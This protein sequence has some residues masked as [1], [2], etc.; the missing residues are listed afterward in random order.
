MPTILKLDNWP[1]YMLWL[2]LKPPANSSSGW[3]EELFLVSLSSVVMHTDCEQYKMGATGWHSISEYHKTK[4]NIKNKGSTHRPLLPPWC[5]ISLPFFWTPVSR[6]PPPRPTLSKF[7][8]ITGPCSFLSPLAVRH[9][10]R[11]H[12][13]MEESR[14]L[15]G[16]PAVM[17]LELGQQEV[18]HVPCVWH[19]SS[20]IHDQAHYF[21]TI[22]SPQQS[23]GPWPTSIMN[24]YLPDGSQW[25][26]CLLGTGSLLAQW[27]SRVRVLEI[28]LGA[29][30]W[31][32]RKTRQ[33]KHICCRKNW[34]TPAS[35]IEKIPTRNIFA[36]SWYRNWAW[37]SQKPYAHQQH[38]QC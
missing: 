27:G 5:F 3:E 17:V 23:K 9:C 21:Y 34:N 19:P 16:E 1:K 8:S 37:V 11:P 2:H 20:K 35:Q 24:P 30:T 33:V 22:I 18:L 6:N 14:D 36:S 31:C 28:K 38:T 26:I 13:Q 4:N 29:S 10:H 7:S 25:L 32:Q 12:H 15:P